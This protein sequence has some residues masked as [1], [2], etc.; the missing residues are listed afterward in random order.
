VNNNS[1]HLLNVIRSWLDFMIS[2]H[3]GVEHFKINLSSLNLIYIVLNAH[4]GL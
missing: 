2:S 4:L 3:I 1:C